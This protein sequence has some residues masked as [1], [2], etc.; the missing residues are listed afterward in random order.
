MKKLL[1]ILVAATMTLTG[2]AAGT[3]DGLSK[4][5]AIEFDWTNGNTQEA[6]T[7]WY[8]VTFGDRLNIDAPSLALYLTNLSS[9][10]AEVEITAHYAGDEE[11]RE[12]MING[13]DVKVWNTSASMIKSMVKDEEGLFIKLMSK[14]K[15]HF[16]A[17]V[18]EGTFAD[19]ACLK[20]VAYNFGETAQPLAAGTHWYAI[21]LKSLRDNKQGL[22]ITY[23]ANKGTSKI[24]SMISTDCP[25]TGLTGLKGSIPNGKTKVHE[26]SAALVQSMPEMISTLYLKVENSKEILVTTS[27]TELPAETNFADFTDVVWEQSYDVTTAGQIFRTTFAQ[28]LETKKVQPVINLNNEDNKTLETEVTVEIALSENGELASTQNYSI[29]KETIN[30]G[31]IAFMDFARNMVES[32]DTAKYKYVY[33]RITPKNAIKVSARLKKAHESDA[34]LTAQDV[35]WKEPI[36]LDVL[37]DEASTTAWYAI[38]ITDIKEHPQDINITVTNR[39]EETAEVTAEAVFECPSVAESV[40]RKIE[41]GKSL[42]KEIKYSSIGAIGSDK[43]YV[44]VTSTQSLKI[45]ISTKPAKEK[46]ASEV[47]CVPENTVPF[48]WE[49]GNRQKANTTVWYSVPADKIID[50]DYLPEI[51][52]TNEG[53]KTLTI[54]GELSLD[55]PDKYE[56]QVRSLSIAANDVYSKVISKEMVNKLQKG[57]ILYIK[58]TANQD[59]NFRLNKKVENEGASC[60]KAIPFNWTTGHN[61][62]ANTTLWYVIDL[63]T[64]KNA[65]GKKVTLILKNLSKNDAQ[66][67][68]L[69]SSECPSTSPQ[70]QSFQLKGAQ[71]KSKGF[72]RSNFTAFGKQVY[73]RIT[74]TQKF[75]FEANL[76]S[77]AT[78]LAAPIT[79]EEINANATEVKVNQPKEEEWNHKTSDKA[80]YKVATAQLKSEELAPRIMV[81]NG[82]AAQTIKASITYVCPVK[83][84][85]MSRSQSFAAKQVISK[86]IEQ[87]MVNQIA[88]Q[89]EYIY[90]YVEATQDYQFRIDMVDPNTGADCM[91]AREI[92]KDKAL[93]HEAGKTLWYKLNV[94]NLIKNEADKKLLFSIR[95][96]DGKAGTVHAA[97]FTDCE[98]KELMTGNASVGANAKREKAVMVEALMGLNTQWLYLQLTA[99]QAQS[100]LMTIVNRTELP[101][102]EQVDLCKDNAIVTPFAVNTDY[103]QKANDSVWYAVNIKEIREN[104]SGDAT[105][106]VTELSGEENTLKAELSWVCEIK[107]EMSSKSMML[108]GNDVYNRV[109]SRDMLNTPEGKEI[110]YIRVI[111]EKAMK[112]RVNMHLNKGDECSNPIVFD[113]DKGNINPQGTCLWYRVDLV[114]ENNELLIPENKDLQLIIVN[115]GEQKSLVSADVRWACGEPS[116]GDKQQTI[117]PKDTVSKIIDRDRIKMLGDPTSIVINLCTPSAAMFIKAIFIDE[118]KRDTLYKDSLVYWCDSAEFI[119]TYT[120][121]G[122]VTRH[123]PYSGDQASLEWADTL[124]V[125]VGT[126]VVDSIYRF[127]IVPLTAAEAFGQTR[128]DALTQDTIVAEEGKAFTYAD[129][130]KYLETY[131]TNLTAADSLADFDHIEG[132]MIYDEAQGDWTEAEDVIKTDSVLTDATTNI[133][134][135]YQ[136]YTGCVE[137]NGERGIIFDTIRVVVTKKE[138][139]VPCDPVFDISNLTLTWP[140]PICGTIYD[141]EAVKA[142]VQAALD[143]AG[144]TD[145][146]TIH[147][148]G[149]AEYKNDTMKAGEEVTFYAKVTSKCEVPTTSQSAAYTDKVVNSEGVNMIT[150]LPLVDPFAGENIDNKILLIDVNAINAGNYGL[151]LPEYYDTENLVKWYRMVG[152]EA[153]PTKDVLVQDHGYYLTTDNEKLES[154]AYYAVIEVVNAAAGKCDGEWRTIVYAVSKPATVSKRM[155]NGKLYIVTEDNVIYDA[156]GQKVQ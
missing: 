137:S 38:T 6:G 46:E 149:D 97:A 127:K 59:F 86:T 2:F 141:A 8:R 34:C 25:S 45:E 128:Y 78:M 69:L 33:V 152:T 5:D 138:T 132:W 57:Q 99:A 27:K 154:G 40:T 58:L 100:L 35:N 55:C 43:I 84:E 93:D 155:I 44:G 41:T 130:A 48:N 11:K 63:D 1:L 106:I 67:D 133:Q 47:T 145:I 139:E 96:T 42:T 14:Q 113:W 153:D 13:N 121:P 95:N 140:K 16:S 65:E 114:D 123:Y 36:Y 74:T 148:N 9:S 156:Q 110:A 30:A 126:M 54:N 92:V 144:S 85:M 75:H 71:V 90:I 102:S 135:A 88:S 79:C 82:D 103:N 66:I 49:E 111:S 87:S 116:L 7:Y 146:V 125:P 109:F 77:A 29:K 143:A 50:A 115:Q 104:T 117:A 61:Q 19:D 24:V 136:A 76:D 32:I 134:L 37:T 51:I 10:V 150:T 72:A 62:D 107:Y 122:Y 3:G 18:Y 83:E 108:K 17:K 151:K 112:F 120:Q 20:A 53:D 21:D 80:W 73:I 52:I 124:H 12:Y 89:H 68:G 142:Q 119:D 91:H 131:Y 28:I 60:A 101:E 64:I 94:A 98:G 81:E 26:I 147:Y 129:F 15:V 4:A 105:L 70:S 56:N 118:I 22:L 31:E 39:G 23:A